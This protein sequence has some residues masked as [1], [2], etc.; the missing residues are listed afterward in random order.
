MAYLFRLNLFIYPFSL[1]IYSLILVIN[2][3]IYL[4]INF[5][6]IYLGIHLAGQNVERSIPTVGLK[7]KFFMFYLNA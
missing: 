3:F 2:F 4:F 6:I 5:S 7:K 1:F